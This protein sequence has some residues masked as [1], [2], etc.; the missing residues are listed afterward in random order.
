[1]NTAIEQALC[2]LGE[3]PVNVDEWD[4]NDKHRAANFIDLCIAENAPDDTIEITREWLLQIGFK[5]GLYPYI[6]TPMGMIWWVSDPQFDQ[7]QPGMHGAHRHMPH[8]KTR[9][10]LRR[11]LK[12]LGIEVPK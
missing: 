7:G 5:K 1:M 6:E 2:T 11:L 10:D 8:I 4:D 12:A 3:L 9:G